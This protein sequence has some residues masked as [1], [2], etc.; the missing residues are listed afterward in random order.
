MYKVS[1]ENCEKKMV[2][3]PKDAYDKAP[4]LFFHLNYINNKLFN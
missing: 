3:H 1:H 4:L 2:G